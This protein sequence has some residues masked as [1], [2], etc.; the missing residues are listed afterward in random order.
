MLPDASRFLLPRARLGEGEA[1]FAQFPD[2]V[3]S[4]MGRA[5]FEAGTGHEDILYSIRQT[6]NAFLQGR[7]ALNRNSIPGKKGMSSFFNALI[8]TGFYLQNTVFFRNCL[9]NLDANSIRLSISSIWNL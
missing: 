4:A 9:E 8:L 1:A 2:L 7:K 6:K 5:G 3:L